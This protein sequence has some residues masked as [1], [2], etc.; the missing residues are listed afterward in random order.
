MADVQ[1]LKRA[2]DILRS[3]SG[4]ADGASLAVVSREVD[5]PKSTVA[6][7]LATLEN[8]GAVERLVDADGYRIG[9]AII[10]L[11]A[12]VAYPRSLVALARPALQSLAQQS[13]ETV[14]LGI[15]EGGWALTL[16]QIDSRHNVRLRNWVGER[17]PLHCTSDGKLYLA[18][19]P[20]EAMHAYLAQ[21]L[22]SFSPYT[23][24]DPVALQAELAQIHQQGYAWNQREHDPDIVSL[25]AP[26]Y[27]ENQQV[28][29][30]ICMF[31]P[32][33]RFPPAGKQAEYIALTVAAARQV[34]ERMQQLNHIQH[35]NGQH[36]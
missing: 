15:P 14:S 26:I 35:R 29:A 27:D 23:I 34:T 16:D 17:L 11:A 4:H 2:F 24:T 22:A 7:L 33:F 32:F 9:T 19:W 36:T 1:S 5:L 8:L 3:V 28:I 12:Q 20:A 21:P 31:G 13:G 30:A 6:R 10:T 25:A 18:A